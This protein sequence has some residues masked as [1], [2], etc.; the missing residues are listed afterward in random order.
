MEDRLHRR[1]RE[2]VHFEVVRDPEMVGVQGCVR[3]SLRSRAD[4]RTPDPGRLKSQL[5]SFGS[6]VSIALL[7][8]EG[9][10]NGFIRTG[11]NKQWPAISR[12]RT[13]PWYSGLSTRSS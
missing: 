3:T 1:R 2:T 6:Q 9:A 7:R 8:L 11:G 4:R 13:R 10:V 5:G 12:R